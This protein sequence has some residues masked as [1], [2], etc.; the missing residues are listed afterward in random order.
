MLSLFLS[1]EISRLL[2]II[3]PFFYYIIFQKFL[4][5][6]SSIHLPPTSS[7]IPILFKQVFGE[8]IADRSSQAH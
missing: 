8:D 2:R 6:Q 7:L 1:Q 5:E 3:I 4:S